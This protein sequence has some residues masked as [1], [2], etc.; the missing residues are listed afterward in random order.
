MMKLTIDTPNDYIWTGLVIDEKF[1]LDAI[2]C[3][4]DSMEKAGV[5]VKRTP[6]R[7]AIAVILQRPNLIHGKS[8]TNKLINLQPVNRDIEFLI[9]V[10]N[11]API[12]STPAEV[13]SAL[14]EDVMVGNLWVNAAASLMAWELP[15]SKEED[16]LLILE[17][18]LDNLIEMGKNDEI[19]VLQA[20]SRNLGLSVIEKMKLQHLC[21][22]RK[23]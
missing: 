2:E 15:V 11:T 12:K 10:V 9:K 21:L 7:E 17:C 8:V 20:K 3:K 1:V 5:Q 4:I 6:V 13:L 22:N 16:Y 23:V 14:R 19:D 18:A